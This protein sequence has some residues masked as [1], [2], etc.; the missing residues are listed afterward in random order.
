MV[1]K[2]IRVEHE[3]WDY[4][5]VHRSENMRADKRATTT[6]GRTISDRS[7]SPIWRH[8]PFLYAFRTAFKLRIQR[9]QT[10]IHNPRL[11]QNESS[12]RKMRTQ[13]TEFLW[14]N[15]TR[16]KNEFGGINA[17]DGTR[18]KQRTVMAAIV[19]YWRP[20]YLS[21]CRCDKIVCCVCSGEP[22][23]RYL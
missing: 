22:W 2:H 6:P 5:Q 14:V 13:R 17:S 9:P 8:P 23:S 11:L 3:V 4:R 18:R 10:R 15:D 20:V 7:N 19:V 12:S 16:P 1:S 21:L